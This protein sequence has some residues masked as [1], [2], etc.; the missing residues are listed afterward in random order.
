MSDVV[1]VA[2]EI[3]QENIE[4]A[5]AQRAAPS[6]KESALECG[7]CGDEIPEARRVAVAG[8]QHCTECAGI[9]E[10]KHFINGGK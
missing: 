7:E 2:N 5:L 9:L 4:R 10:R 1:D 3:M 8:T 6:K